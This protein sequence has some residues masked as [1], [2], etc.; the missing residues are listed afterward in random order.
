MFPSEL[1]ITMFEHLVLDLL[2]VE[3]DYYEFMKVRKIPN[4]IRNISQTSKE[5]KCLFEIVF[6]EIFSEQ[7]GINLNLRMA[8]GHLLENVIY[9]SEFHLKSVN[10]DLYAEEL[11]RVFRKLGCF[12]KFRDLKMII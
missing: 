12:Q 1:I 11:N 6:K 2:H 4:I 10:Y 9:S 3:Y 7:F 5:Y 8:H